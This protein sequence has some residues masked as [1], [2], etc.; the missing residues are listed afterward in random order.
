M[1]SVAGSEKLD[2][3]QEG[4]NASLRRDKDGG[5]WDL[6]DDIDMDKAGQVRV[7]RGHAIYKTIVALR[8][9]RI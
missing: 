3:G 7:E 1:S 4:N 6:E 9:G 2:F 5:C 8:N